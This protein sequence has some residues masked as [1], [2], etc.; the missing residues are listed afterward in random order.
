MLHGLSHCGLSPQLC[1]PQFIQ[2]IKAAES[3]QEVLHLVCRLHSSFDAINSVTAL[4]KMAKLMRPFSRQAMMQHPGMELLLGLAV[5]QAPSFR[6]QA[7]GNALWALAKMQQ[8][9]S[10]HL[11]RNLT[12]AVHRNLPAFTSQ[13]LATSIWGS[14]TIGHTPDSE[15]LAAIAKRAPIILTDAR[16]VCCISDL[17]LLVA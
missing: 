2:L 5:A 9:P 6:E 13:H 1:R 15:L 17:L 11:L 4:H 10:A 14:A 12:A 16:A 8:S 3:W 7:T